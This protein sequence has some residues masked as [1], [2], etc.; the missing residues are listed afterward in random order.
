MR[1][2]RKGTSGVE[3][4][5]KFVNHIFK[6]YKEKKED[7]L[8]NFLQLISK[9]AETDFSNESEDEYNKNKNAKPKIKL[10]FE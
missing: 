8:N 6:G 9:I 4:L 7:K 10:E 2:L 1:L 5:Y 3:L